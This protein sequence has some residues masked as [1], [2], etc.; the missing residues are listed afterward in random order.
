MVHKEDS[1]L[2]LDLGVFCFCLFDRF[3]IG[4]S[5]NR[6]DHFHS[7]LIEFKKIE[8]GTSTTLTQYGVVHFSS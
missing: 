8:S 4:G 7:Y 3:H 2:P 6:S 5:L 1:P